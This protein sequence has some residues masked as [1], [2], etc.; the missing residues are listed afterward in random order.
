MVGCGARIGGI[1]QA[2][3]SCGRGAGKSGGH[4]IV[5]ETVISTSGCWELRGVY[6]TE[7]PEGWGLRIGEAAGEQRSEGH[8]QSSVFR[9]RAGSIF[10]RR[11]QRWISGKSFP[12]ARFF[13]FRETTRKWCLSACLL[14]ARGAGL[15]KRGVGWCGAWR[16]RA[17]RG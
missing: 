1:R 17:A 2:I 3:E 12:M 6:K 14:A 13:C 8:F 5:I 9:K 16:G 15:G 4:G 10:S 11:W 7:S